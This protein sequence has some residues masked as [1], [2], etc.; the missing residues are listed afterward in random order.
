MQSKYLLFCGLSLLFTF[1]VILTYTLLNSRVRFA[2][3]DVNSTTLASSSAVLARQVP[4]QQAAR[5]TTDPNPSNPLPWTSY[6]SERYGFLV[7]APKEGASIGCHGK[8]TP[9]VDPEPF[10]FS[11]SS[12]AEEDLGPIALVITQASKA[13]GSTLNS[14][15]D[16]YVTAGVDT[17]YDKTYTKIDGLPSLKFKIK[18][19]AH[20]IA[21]D[22][23]EYGF[24]DASDQPCQI[25]IID[26]GNRYIYINRPLWYDSKIIQQYNGPILPPLFTAEEAQK[27]YN[28]IIGSIK[29]DR[30]A[31]TY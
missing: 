1:G 20:Y 26:A 16:L 31:T 13:P 18:K 24:F 4:Q 15:I 21:S 28:D 3:L 10:V 25:Y 12:N 22:A 11:L 19:G 23:A 27:V 8:C 5:P 29:I 6:R 14:W 30:G 7:M 17:I 2:P 9:G